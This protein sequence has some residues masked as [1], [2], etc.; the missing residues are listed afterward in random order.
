MKKAK[1]SADRA[2]KKMVSAGILLF[3]RTAAGGEVFLAHPGG[4]FWKHKDE[5]AWTI[6]KG[7]VGEGETELQAALREFHEETGQRADGAPLPLGTVRQK[8]GK[9]IH[10]WAVEGDADPALVKSNLVS[11]PTRTGWARFPEVDRCAWFDAPTARRKL[12]PAQAE[13]IDRLLALL[14][15]EKA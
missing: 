4:P 10:A 11:M 6:P 3:R 9:L 14:A 1:T 7:L 2:D 13:L 5:G 12:N 8:A 15:A